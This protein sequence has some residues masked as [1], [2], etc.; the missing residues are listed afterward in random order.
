M[1]HTPHN[2]YRKCTEAPAFDEGRAGNRADYSVVHRHSQSMPHVLATD[3]A[4]CIHRPKQILA[5]SDISLSSNGVQI[6]HH[7]HGGRPPAGALGPKTN[8]LT[9]FKLDLQAVLRSPGLA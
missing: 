1:E 2:I 4:T 9:H 8:N 3:Q 5:A 6:T 7:T